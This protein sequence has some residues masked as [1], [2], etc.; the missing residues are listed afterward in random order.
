M[1]IYQNSEDE[2]VRQ[3]CNICG[4]QILTKKQLKRHQDEVHKNKGFKCTECDHWFKLKWSL[5]QHI[6][7]VHEGVKYPCKQCDHKASSK[8]ILP[9]TKEQ[10]EKG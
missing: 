5:N 7:I 1:N 8:R 6:R 9:N 2:H 3:S 4:K 10:F